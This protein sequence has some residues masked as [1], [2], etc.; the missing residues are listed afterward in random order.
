MEERLKREKI[1]RREA[2][3]YRNQLREELGYKIK[4]LPKDAIKYIREVNKKGSRISVHDAFQRMAA[5][6]DMSPSVFRAMFDIVVVMHQRIASL[7]QDVWPV[8]TNFLGVTNSRLEQH[9]VESRNKFMIEARA[10]RPSVSVVIQEEIHMG[11]ST[12][13]AVTG[14]EKGVLIKAKVSPA[15]FSLISKLGGASIR[16]QYLI[17]NARKVKEPFYGASIYIGEV[18]N[19]KGEA[20]RLFG[21]FGIYKDGDERISV[22]NDGLEKTE[23]MLRVHVSRRVTDEMTS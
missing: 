14:A 15:W 9:N 5:N 18:I 19:L 21:Y 22:Y 12:V 8:H 2:F 17:V 6:P 20:K 11:S 7:R 23:R 13:V 1:L 4:L 16:N 10:I 3:K